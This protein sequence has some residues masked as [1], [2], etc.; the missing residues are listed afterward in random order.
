M[1][2][3]FDCGKVSLE[4]LSKLDISYPC[5]LNLEPPNPRKKDGKREES[6]EC[7]FK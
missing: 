1:F 2:V 7:S 3:Q 6:F 4:D 5:Y